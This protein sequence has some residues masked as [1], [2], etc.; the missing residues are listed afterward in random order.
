MIRIRRLIT[1]F[2]PCMRS[3]S[4]AT[5]SSVETGKMF[6]V[7]DLIIKSQQRQ[8]HRN[9]YSFNSFIP[10]FFLGAVIAN[11]SV[12]NCSSNDDDTDNAKNGNNLIWNLNN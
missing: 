4:G 1:P 10:V 8:N 9:N 6:A 11:C 5:F 12:A 3:L 7:N 2:H